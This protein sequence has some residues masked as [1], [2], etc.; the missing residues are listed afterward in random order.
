MKEEEK[1][2]AGIN[3]YEKQSKEVKKNEAQDK[4]DYDLFLQSY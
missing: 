4:Q 1:E 3:N 2:V